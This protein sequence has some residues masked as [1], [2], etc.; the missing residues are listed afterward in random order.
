MVGK[1][2][3]LT[4]LCKFTNFLKITNKCTCFFCL[5]TNYL[6]QTLKRNTVMSPS[7]KT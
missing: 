6:P 5:P 3:S 1:V 4:T 7:W 2:T